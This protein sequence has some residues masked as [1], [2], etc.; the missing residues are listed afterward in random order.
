MRRL[1]QVFE[2]QQQSFLLLFLDWSNAFDSVSFHSMESA[3]LHFGVPF[4]LV[5]VILFRHSPPKFTV[6]DAG[7]SSE[8]SSQ[9][10]GFRQGCPFSPY[11]FNFLLSHLFHDVEQSYVSQFGLLSGIINTIFPFWDL[12]KPMTP[13]SFQTLPSKSQ[14]FCTFC[15]FMFIYEGSPLT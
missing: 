11:L 12:E 13:S 1:L 10:G 14:S 7:F 3:L 15:N 4:G 9:T 8:L 5:K 6:R 2:R